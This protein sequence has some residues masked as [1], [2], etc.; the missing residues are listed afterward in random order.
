MDVDG[1][2]EESEL[3]KIAEWDYKDFCS[4]MQ[5]IKERWK[6]ADIGYFD[7]INN[8]YQFSTGGWSGNESIISALQENVMFWACCWQSSK[9]G[10][11][12]VFRVR[13][14]A[15]DVAIRIIEQLQAENERLKKEAKGRLFSFKGW[16]LMKVEGVPMGQIWMNP[17][18]PILKSI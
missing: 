5:Y 15:G 11:H 16:I 14:G 8:I 4:L 7:G 2:P 1:Y 9:R 3:Q 13:E 18:E 6:Y 17:D 10:G 12:Y